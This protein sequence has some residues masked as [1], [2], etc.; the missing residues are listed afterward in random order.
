MPDTGLLLHLRPPQLSQSIRNEIGVRSGDQVSV[1]YDPMIAKLVVHGRDRTEALRL[2]KK[3]LQGYEVVGPSTNI[4]FLK[5]CI[6]N[7]DFI[8]GDVETGFIQVY[9][10]LLILET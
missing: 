9:Y 4:D 8:A 3:A 2:M 1:Y 7:P 6:K 5:R 10:F